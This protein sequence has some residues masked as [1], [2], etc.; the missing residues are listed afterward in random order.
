MS[1]FV[2]FGNMILPALAWLIL[3]SELNF[4]IPI[5][6]LSFRPWR[7]LVIFYG[8]PSVLFGLGVL[9]FPESPKFLMTQG[10]HDEAL[11]ILEKMFAFNTGRPLTEYPVT[12]IVWDSIDNGSAENK[13]FL[14]CMWDQTLALIKGQYALKT[15][16]V[17]F[18]Q[19]GTFAA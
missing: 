3:P 7:L 12:S 5:L 9:H 2:A 6:N 1:I 13:G 15:F 11:E 4:Y 18:L 14:F 10:R 8:L 17:C 16:I 19:L